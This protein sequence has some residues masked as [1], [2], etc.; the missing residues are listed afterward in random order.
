VW[1]RRR[2]DAAPGAWPGVAAHGRPAWHAPTSSRPLVQPWRHGT[3][4]GQP[5]RGAL[6][7]ACAV[8]YPARRLAAPERSSAR[9][10]V[11]CAPWRGAF[12]STCS[13]RALAGIQPL[14]STERPPSPSSSR[15]VNSHVRGGE[16][17]VEAI[18][19]FM[20]EVVLA[21]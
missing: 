8:A 21:A 5:P 2:A 19:L 17:E 12:A 7:A 13:Q 9:P 15:R 3:V 16:R 20:R 1:L 4:R 6:V 10:T 18:V 14:W 11:A